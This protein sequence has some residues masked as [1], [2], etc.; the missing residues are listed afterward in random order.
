MPL[1]TFYRV[2]VFFETEHTQLNEFLVLKDFNSSS[3]ILLHNASSDAIRSYH[4]KKDYSLTD[5]ITIP[6]EIVV[7]S[8][9][10]SDIF[11]TFLGETAFDRSFGVQ[12]I[13][14]IACP[15][16]TLNRFKTF[17]KYDQSLANLFYTQLNMSFLIAQSIKCRAMYKPD[18]SLRDVKRSR[19]PFYS[20]FGPNYDV[21]PSF[22]QN[23]LVN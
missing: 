15:N 19:R 6:I 21:I 14:S 10:Q 7:Q 5:G 23:K 18:A 3:L 4:L 2:Y 12:Y 1:L 9:S 13:D 22:P 16:T 8:S 20:D 17:S 11:D